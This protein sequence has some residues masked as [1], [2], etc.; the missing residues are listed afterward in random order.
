MAFLNDIALITNAYKRYKSAADMGHWVEECGT[1]DYNGYVPKFS[2]FYNDNK[3][4]PVALVFVTTDYFREYDV[5]ITATV[6][7]CKRK[8]D[9]SG[10]EEYETK[11]QFGATL[12]RPVY[13]H[14]TTKQI[15]VTIPAWEKPGV[16][17]LIGNEKLVYEIISVTSDIHLP[18]CGA[19]IIF[20]LASV[21]ARLIYGLSFNRLMRELEIISNGI[22]VSPPFCNLCGGT[23]A[24]PLD[25]KQV[26]PQCN[27]FGYSG[28]GAIEFMLKNHGDEVGVGRDESRDIRRYQHEIW[29]QKWWVTPTKS[30]VKKIFAFFCNIPEDDIIIEERYHKQEP[31]WHLLLPDGFG[32]NSQF[33]PS[34]LNDY[35]SLTYLL[36]SVTPA[37]VTPWLTFYSNEFGGTYFYTDLYDMY[38]PTIIYNEAFPCSQWG[39]EWGL[40]TTFPCSGYNMGYAIMVSG[41]VYYENPTC[42]HW[43]LCKQAT[44]E[45]LSGEWVW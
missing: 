28:F 31:A 30:Q 35:K 3:Y 19:G 36:E 1:W 45:D 4:T 15:S 24:N 32:A 11:Q 38:Y 8:K 9:A 43:V 42:M 26:C 12:K 41:E 33:D 39:A 21:G 2:S 14:D 23:G 25:S 40:N 29:A 20:A 6:K 16:A 44:I 10:N 7:T 13:E 18:G 17:Y 22:F 27:G 34:N 37:G 5:T